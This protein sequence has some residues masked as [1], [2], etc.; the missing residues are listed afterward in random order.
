[1]E[2]LIDDK[3]GKFR[4]CNHKNYDYND[5]EVRDELNLKATIGLQLFLDEHC[6]G[7]KNTFG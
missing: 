6:G 7:W 1:L 4:N 5:V 3:N 2:D